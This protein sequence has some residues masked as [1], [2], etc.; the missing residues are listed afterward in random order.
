MKFYRL[1]FFDNSLGK[2]NWESQGWDTDY[3]F[4]SIDNLYQFLERV[5]S[6]EFGEA[7]TKDAMSFIKENLFLEDFC[8]IDVKYFND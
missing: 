6:R 4:C 7:K 2:F 3:Y 1:Q 8:S 5:V